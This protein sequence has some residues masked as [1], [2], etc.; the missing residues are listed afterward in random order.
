[1]QRRKFGLL[2]TIVSPA[3]ALVGNLLMAY[4]VYFIA[5]VAYLLENYEAFSEGLS[6][7]HLCTIFGGGLVFDTSAILYTNMLYIV[8]MLFPLSFKET[9]VYHRICKWLFV[10]VNTLA[11]IIN[12]C[13]SVYFP[14]TLRRTTT[15]V[16]REFDNSSATGILSSWWP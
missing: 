8:M 3:V 15:S 12:L 1:M 10:V 13:D 5:R 4:V 6:L 2:D 11:L 16:F 14:Y 7:S 9:A